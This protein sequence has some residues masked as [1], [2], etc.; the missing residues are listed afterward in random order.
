MDGVLWRGNQPLIDFPEIFQKIRDLNLDVIL[1]TNN[2][3][4]SRE[5]FLRKIAQ[6]GVTLAPRQVIN[7]ALAATYLL[8]EHFPEGGRV[9]VVGESGLVSSLEEQGFIIAKDHVVAVVAGIDRQLT[10]EKIA[11]AMR[12]IRGGAPFYGTNP[13]R[14]YPMPDGLIP[15]AGT[16]LAAIE[17]A[18]DVKPIIVGKP[19]PVM[20]EMAL[21][22]MGLTPE[23]V[24]VVGDRLDTDIAGG[25]AIGCRTALVLSGVTTA[26]EARKW[27]PAPDI[28]CNRL[29]DLF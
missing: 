15:G 27:S 5:S 4:Q 16:I 18:T 28:I 7:S 9:Y 2:S 17:A 8:K 10:Y 1:A 19:E 11:T 20:L 24:L 25:Q 6:Y 12:L 29:S 13:D 22:R 21:T 23:Q 3:T 14:T 26:E